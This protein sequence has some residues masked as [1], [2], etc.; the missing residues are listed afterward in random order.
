MVV[1]EF[2]FK[3]PES[4]RSDNHPAFLLLGN[5]AQGAGTRFLTTD[6]MTSAMGLAGKS[7]SRTFAGE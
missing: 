6:G 4:E 5:Q 2:R 1:H 3:C 7:L